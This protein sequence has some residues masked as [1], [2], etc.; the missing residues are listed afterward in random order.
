MA[1]EPSSEPKAENPHQSWGFRDETYVAEV[2]APPG[3]RPGTLTAVCIIAIILGCLGILSGLSSL[4]A[5]LGANQIQQWQA[6]LG[7]AGSSADA[8]SLEAEMNAKSL[9]IVNRFRLVNVA[10]S[11]FQ[12]A[13]AGMLLAGGIKALGMKDLGR[14]LLR[15]ACGLAILFELSRAVPSTLMQLENMAL[16]ED[17][18]PRVMEASAPGG[19][20]RQL[21]EFGRMMARFS[22]IMGWVIFFGWLTLKLVF[23][24][25]AFAYLGRAKT[26]AFYPLPMPGLAS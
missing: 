4:A 1:T 7:G 22:L 21:A 6:Q 3:Y 5:S 11:V 8:R 13:V 9:A 10:M 19:Q 20:G 25:V 14:K 26:K 24:G 18:L 17:Y 15:I 16:M 2:A 23:F 12:F